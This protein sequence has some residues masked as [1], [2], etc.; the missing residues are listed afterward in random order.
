MI[1]F[2]DGVSAGLGIA[3]PVGAIAI[4]ILDAGMQRGF[5]IAFCAGAGAASADFFFATLAALAGQLLADV[6]APFAVPLR[7]LSAM[8]LIALGARGLWRA[9]GLSAQNARRKSDARRTFTQTYAQFLAL[10]LLNPATIAYFA[11]LILG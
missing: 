10:T 3:I 9:R 8:V 4:L 2:L 11:A 6:I 5:W 7:I 1:P